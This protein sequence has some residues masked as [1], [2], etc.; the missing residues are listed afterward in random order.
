MLN[1][2]Q[3]WTRCDCVINLT[4]NV[5]MYNIYSIENIIKFS[6]MTCTDK[7]WN[8]QRFLRWH[9]SKSNNSTIMN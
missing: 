1:K 3:V 9:S 4:Q 6:S 8:F 5:N 2:C 7:I